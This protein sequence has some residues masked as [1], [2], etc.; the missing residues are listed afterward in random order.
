MVEMEVLGLSPSIKLGVGV[1][2][3]FTIKAISV[4]TSHFPGL[5][6]HVGQAAGLWTR[7][8]S[9]DYS[10]SRASGR[11]S[12][13]SLSQPSL[14]MLVLP[15]FLLCLLRTL[16]LYPNLPS[17]L[18]MLDLSQKKNR[19]ALLLQTLCTLEVWGPG[20]RKLIRVGGAASPFRV[21]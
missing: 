20:C 8:H 10:R 21:D 16:P 12:H 19:V 6:S 17:V 15:G 1:R 2:V 5:S 14:G 4:D 3:Y 18:W 7:A 9:M 11:Y 13:C